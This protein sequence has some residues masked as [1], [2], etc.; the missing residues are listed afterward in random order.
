MRGRESGADSLPAV[1]GHGSDRGRSP[2]GLLPRWLQVFVA[3]AVAALVLS[4]AAWLT[5]LVLSRLGLVTVSL[6]AALLLAALLSPVTS[7]LRAVGAPPALAAAVSVVFLLGVP[8]GIGLLLYTRILDQSDDLAAALTRG[9]DDVRSWLV[10]GPLNLDPVQ[11]DN[12]RD[13]A[14]QYIQSATPTAA[15]GA[16]TALRFLAGLALTFF[17]LFFLMKDGRRMWD[18]AVTWLPASHRSQSAEAGV[19]VWETLR[20]YV[21]GTTAVALADATGVGLALLVLGVPLWL[22]LALLTFVG[23]YVPII[24][25]TVAG[26]AA[27][28][29]TLVTNGGRDALIVLGV[30]LLVQQV[31]GNLL[32]P[33]VMGHAIHLHPLVIIVAV[34]SG[35]LVLG[36]VGAI[37]AVPL[38][39]ITYRVVKQFL[40]P[41]ERPSAG[42]PTSTRLGT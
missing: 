40:G 37:I 27:V 36:I 26:A 6:I 42:P 34:T 9:V 38:V 11:L 28:L 1:D 41:A 16:T 15:A 29:V 39:A 10:D 24:G 35:T 13:G 12:I 22:S 18:W 23:A 4:A 31:E 2:L 7:R 21:F 17:A 20:S 14:V 8:T 32:Q 33:L 19:Q 5:W 3:Y 25:A 30:V